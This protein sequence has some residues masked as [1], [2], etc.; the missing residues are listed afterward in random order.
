MMFASKSL[1]VHRF[2]GSMSC[3]TLDLCFESSFHDYSSI[4]SDDEQAASVLVV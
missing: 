2:G 4:S 1:V 3:R